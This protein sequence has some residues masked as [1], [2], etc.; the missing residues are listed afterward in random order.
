MKLGI[1]YTKCY[2]IDQNSVPSITKV[3]LVLIA[4]DSVQMTFINPKEQDTCQGHALEVHK[5]RLFYTAV[6]QCP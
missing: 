6:P 3:W 5:V 4:T 2:S 1:L